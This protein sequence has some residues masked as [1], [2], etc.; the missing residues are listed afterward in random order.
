MNS[1]TEPELLKKCTSCRSFRAAEL[2]E[3]AKTCYR[4]CEICRTRKR[5]TSVVV[6]PEI[7]DDDVVYTTENRNFIVQKVCNFLPTGTYKLVGL[8]GGI[9]IHLF[10]SKVVIPLDLGDNWKKIKKWITKERPLI[11]DCPICFCPPVNGEV[12]S[13]DNCMTDMCMDCFL[14]IFEKNFGVVSCP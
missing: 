5:K 1:I 6:V 2:F 14:N 13:C 8:K 11:W 3:D 12:S 7:D 4:T 9:Y 10:A